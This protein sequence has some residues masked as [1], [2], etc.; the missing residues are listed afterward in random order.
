MTFP[1]GYRRLFLV[2]HVGASVG[3]LGAEAVLLVLTAAALA[4]ADRHVAYPAA[5]LA[6]G[7]LILPL[8]LLSWLSGVVIA[9][10]TRWGLL[11]HW[12]VVTKLALTTLMAVLVVFVLVPGLRTVGADPDAVTPATARQLVVAPSV[13]TSLLLVNLV[14]SVYKPWGR[15]RPRAAAPAGS[16]ASRIQR[17]P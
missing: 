11:T 2:L 15:L 3:W 16:R 6:G 5:A 1:R 4:G 10:G 8:A 12:W 17:Y 14:L 9:V 13:A 7:L